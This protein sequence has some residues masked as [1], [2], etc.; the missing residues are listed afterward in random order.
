[1]IGGDYDEAALAARARGR[2]WLLPSWARR[3]KPAAEA[4]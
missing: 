2:R 4:V 3:A 1:V